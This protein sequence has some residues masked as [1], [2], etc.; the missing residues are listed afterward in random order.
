M[1]LELAILQKKRE[2]ALSGGGSV[3]SGRPTPD[4]GTSSSSAAMEAPAPYQHDVEVPVPMPGQAPEKKRA[5][6]L[7]KGR[8]SDPSGRSTPD[9]GSSSAPKLTGNTTTDDTAGEEEDWAAVM[10]A[11]V[12]VS[13]KHP[14]KGVLAKKYTAKEERPAKKEED[15]SKGGE[16]KVPLQCSWCKVTVD[17]CS[18]F[19]LHHEGKGGEADF[20]TW[21]GSTQ[22]I[23]RTNRRRLL[24]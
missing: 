10:Q 20:E 15:P 7:Q 24:H 23:G 16:E 9:V 18:Q 2:L 8:G 17:K 6:K 1:E 21:A 4:V 19:L 14:T 12:C 3:L 13:S 5:R 22:G 11:E